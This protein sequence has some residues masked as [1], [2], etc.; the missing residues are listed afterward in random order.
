[1]SFVIGFRW[2]PSQIMVF[3]RSRKVHPRAENLSARSCHR[4]GI[5][6]CR[7]WMFPI[8]ST[9]NH[10]CLWKRKR[11]VFP[12]FGTLLPYLY[13]FNINK[14]NSAGHI[15]LFQFH[16]K[17]LSWCV[18]VFDKTNSVLTSTHYRFPYFYGNRWCHVCR[19]DCRRRYWNRLRYLY[20]P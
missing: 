17:I 4:D 16:R 7:L 10:Q 13:V 15:K 2:E 3:I 12:V 9:A 11:I 14:W 8:I 5:I 1:M 20:D 18:Y 6:L 19:S